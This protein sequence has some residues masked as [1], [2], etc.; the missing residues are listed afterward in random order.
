MTRKIRWVKNPYAYPPH[1]PLYEEEDME[2]LKEIFKEMGRQMLS[3]ERG[4]RIIED[5]EKRPSKI[6]AC[7]LWQ[8]QEV[9]AVLKKLEVSK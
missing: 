5:L 7:D 3:P 9:F 6:R 2:L 8:F 4:L 1:I